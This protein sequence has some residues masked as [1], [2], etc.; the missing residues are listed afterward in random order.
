MHVINIPR[1][2][3]ITLVEEA[4]ARSPLS[5]TDALLLKRQAEEA[6]ALAFGLC[7]QTYEGKPCACPAVRA[8]MDLRMGSDVAF[9]AGAFDS[10]VQSK[11]GLEFWADGVLVIA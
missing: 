7:N 9:F 5:A 10:I 4:I 11:Y 6:P 1:D 8:G 3:V 2:E